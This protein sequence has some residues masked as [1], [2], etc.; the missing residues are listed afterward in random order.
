MSLNVIIQQLIDAGKIVTTSPLNVDPANTFVQV[1]V[2]D[3][4]SRKLGPA[5]P[6][7][8]VPAVIPL[9]DLIAGGGVAYTGS[10][11]ITLVGNDFQF[12]SQNISQFTNDSGYIT[13]AGA[14]V[15][16]GNSLGAL[17]Y[18]GTNDNFDFPIYTNGIERLRVN[19]LGE[20]IFT[21]GTTTIKLGAYSATIPAIWLNQATPDITNYFVLSTAAGPQINGVDRI[22]FNVLGVNYA[23]FDSSRN[24]FTQKTMIGSNL[25]PVAMLE[26]RGV[27]GTAAN[28]S[29]RARDVAATDLL[30]VRNDGNIGIGTA[31]PGAKL[32][33]Q[34]S[35]GA[36][37][38][39]LQLYSTD[40]GTPAERS[41]MYL[42]QGE[43]FWRA[44]A[45]NIHASDEA[46]D[47]IV[48]IQ[49]SSNGTLQFYSTAVG[50]ITLNIVGSNKPAISSLNS[51]LLVFQTKTLFQL[52]N[53]INPGAEVHIKAEDDVSLCLIAENDSGANILTAKGNGRVA[54]ENLPT[55]AASLSAGDLWND[56][57]TVK[58][59]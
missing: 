29:F 10:N 56:L 20:T 2:H 25:T 15:P 1:G 46:G 39:L 44:N 14:W 32:D 11:G 48:T 40:W 50:A 53:T 30:V 38:L 18:I 36:G 27:D 16:G 4:R 51:G 9:A 26:V 55:S 58:I 5:D 22:S 23:R 3:P 13:A 34:G 43:M 52:A 8:Y 33:V 59:V 37:E 57:G 28:Y 17:S 47:A 12:T 24:F 54:M 21:T 19:T 49:G 35:T 31:S 7:A 45:T 41:R 6:N 42:T